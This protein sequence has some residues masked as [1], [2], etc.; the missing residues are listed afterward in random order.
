MNDT[1]LDK[2]FADARAAMRQ[3]VQRRKA[4]VPTP[5]ELSAE[6]RLR[7]EL[8][9]IANWTAVRAVT[10]VHQET[11]TLLG[12]FTEY[13]HP[14]VPGARRLVREYEQLP[15]TSVEYV[16]GQ[17]SLETPL[18]PHASHIWH[19]S[20]E[21]MIDVVLGKMH[22][23]SPFVRLSAWFG[24]GR[25][26]RVL[27]RDDTVFTHPAQATECVILPAGTDVLNE[28]ST[29][30]LDHLMTTLSA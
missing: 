6:E 2:L 5:Q 9:P 18:P 27:L 19:Q 14:K 16:T 26:E 8:A 25:L 23:S 1:S 13:H 10:L 30:T 7:K 4:A 29:R 3:Q 28:L 21:A 15:S 17:W 24:E 11:T 12:T 22:L 20:R